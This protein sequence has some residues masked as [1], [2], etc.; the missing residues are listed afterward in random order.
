MHYGGGSWRSQAMASG[1]E[2]HFREGCDVPLHELD[3]HDRIG[4][5][6]IVMYDPN[7]NGIDTAAIVF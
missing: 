2:G 1:V 7:R 5:G 4:I 3:W 6:A